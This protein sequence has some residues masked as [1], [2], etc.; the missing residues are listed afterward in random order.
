MKTTEK[1]GSFTE[2]FCLPKNVTKSLQ[3]IMEMFQ[4]L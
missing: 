3:I 1:P 4:I 2:L